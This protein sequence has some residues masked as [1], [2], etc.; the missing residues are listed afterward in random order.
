MR[1]HLLAQPES[2]LSFSNTQYCDSHAISFAT[3]VGVV[4]W[5]SLHSLVASSMCASGYDVIRLW[6][7][8]DFW[9][10]MLDLACECVRIVNVC[11]LIIYEYLYIYIYI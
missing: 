3:S 4:E 9:V 1:M 5:R 10:S 11:A 6:H 7:D 8:A 2:Y